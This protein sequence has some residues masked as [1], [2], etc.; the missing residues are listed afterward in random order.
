MSHHVKMVW[1]PQ[2]IIWGKRNQPSER[3]ALNPPQ[4]VDFLVLSR[5]LLY[6]VTGGKKRSSILEAK[7][8]DGVR[9]SSPLT[10]VDS[11]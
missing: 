10:D 5:G 6:R 7:G 9:R 4:L 3:G 2:Q 1:T 11:S 8:R